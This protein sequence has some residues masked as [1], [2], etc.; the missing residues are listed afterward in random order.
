[1]SF[2]SAAH[3]PSTGVAVVAT[4]TVC[5]AGLLASMLQAPAAHAWGNGGDRPG[6]H[7]TVKN[8]YG[9][10]DWV[11]DQ[12]YRIAGGKARV[13]SWFDPATARQWS[14]YPDV[15]RTKT[16]HVFMESG[17]GRGA[18]EQA[19]LYYVEAV[20][21]YRAHDYQAAS[22]AFGIL[23]HFVADVSMPYHS[24]RDP[25]AN[26]KEAERYEVYTSGL[27]SSRGS[28]HDLCPQPT[29]LPRVS[30]VRRVISDIAAR[31]RTYYPRLSSILRSSGPAKATDITRA[32]LP[33]SCNNLAALLLS[34]P[35]ASAMPAQVAR[36]KVKLVRTK[37]RIG[38]TPKIDLSAYDSRGR[39]IDGA[40]FR[41]DW[42]GSTHDDTL[43][44]LPDGPKRLHGALERSPHKGT[45]RVTVSNPGA[46]SSAVASGSSSRAIVIAKKYRVMTVAQLKAARHKARKAGK[47]WR[48]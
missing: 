34:I 5:T 43:Y 45:V 11:I 39:R 29:A 42:P 48:P 38:L 13:G 20:R 14:G 28:R 17:H 24:K 1:M 47:P 10:H 36:V 44:T 19:S 9:T 25:R 6:P 23:G 41:V 15:Y 2:S 26:R 7:K 16:Q 33:L 4:A 21:A 22:R 8:G 27:T 3:R 32:V 12:A 37:V 40:L 18:A 35:K 30:D 46:V 31:S